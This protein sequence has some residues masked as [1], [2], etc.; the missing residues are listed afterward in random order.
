MT[1]NN[2]INVQPMLIFIPDISGFSNF[3]MHTDIAHSKHIIGELLELLIDA[4]EMDL[5]VSEIEGDA[6]LF[7]KLCPSV[8]IDPLLT[9]VE[10]MYV[11]FHTH[12][13]KYES[14]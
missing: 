7:Y 10:A 8:S 4:N 14:L 11:K 9:Q 3:V 6:I 1:E 2:N 5:G 12:L 13:K